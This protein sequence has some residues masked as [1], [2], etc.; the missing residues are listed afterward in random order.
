[1]LSRC[2][3]FVSTSDSSEQ[4]IAADNIRKQPESSVKV[5]ISPRNK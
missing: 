3:L 4:N 2:S 1:L 5:K